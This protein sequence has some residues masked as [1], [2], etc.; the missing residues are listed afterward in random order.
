MNAEIRFKDKRLIE[1]LEYIDDKYIEDVFNVL[2]EPDMVHS[3]HK[4]T[5]PFKHWRQYL[6]LAA[7]LVLLAFATPIFG[8]VSEFISSLAAGIGSD[9]SSMTESSD[10][11]EETANNVESTEEEEAQKIP[12]FQYSEV[13][14]ISGDASIKPVSV[15]IGYT[16]YKNEESI[17]T[18]EIGG[19][20]K[21]IISDKG[22]YNYQYFPHLTLDGSLTSSLPENV[23]L[24]YFEVYRTDWER[25]EY[26]FENLY[27]LSLL[28]AGDYIIV[29]LENE[30]IP[31][32]QPHYVVG[33]YDYKI[34]RSA[35]VF[36]LTITK[37]TESDNAP[38][39]LKFTPELEEIDV[40]T[41]LE[42]KNAWTE[43]RRNDSYNSIYSLYS[44][45]GYTESEVLA[46]AE[47]AANSSAESAY[48]EFFNST[49]FYYY[50]YLGTVNDIVV[51]GSY[52][53]ANQPLNGLTIGDIDYGFQA[54]FY[55]YFN[56]QILS[57]EEAYSNNLV[58]REDLIL[59]KERNEKYIEIKYDYYVKQFEQATQK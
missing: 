16:W 45:K 15:H 3:E 49:N 35:I 10:Y 52:S 1:A 47:N 27:E 34:D 14:I 4:I 41:M 58:S 57:L 59:I 46:L 17:W 9:T 37:Q 18:E 5:S 42:V 31:Y 51:L 8:Y 19:G 6:T 26:T 53:R 28:P 12:T 43:Y 32:E 50:G 20:W 39:Y 48:T 24:S 22:K 23:T 11:Y 30:K 54:R 55:L 13:K 2:K 36:A 56:E 7:C 33:E 40:D 44:N 25:T 21:Y 38:N 29:G